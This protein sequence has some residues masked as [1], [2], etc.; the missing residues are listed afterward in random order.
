MNS[1]NSN[2]LTSSS[3][4]NIIAKRSV[5]EVTEESVGNCK[6]I[7]PNFQEDINNVVP[8]SHGYMTR[9]KLKQ[10]Q[11]ASDNHFKTNVSLGTSFDKDKSIIQ[12]IKTTKKKK[13]KPTITYKKKVELSYDNNIFGTN[14][15]LIKTSFKKEKSI[16]QPRKTI[17]IKKPSKTYKSKSKYDVTFNNCLLADKQTH[18]Q[19]Q[20]LPSLFESDSDLEIDYFQINHSKKSKVNE[21]FASSPEI[22]DIRPVFN[23][24][25]EIKTYYNKKSNIVKSQLKATYNAIGNQLIS[26]E[27]NFLEKM[28][29]CSVFQNNINSNINTTDVMTYQNTCDTIK[30][31][32]NKKLEMFTNSIKNHDS[33]LNG[34][35]NFKLVKSNK[36][37][38][39]QLDSKCCCRS[40][41]NFNKDANK[42]STSKTKHFAFDDDKK[43]FQTFLQ[44][45][46]LEA[47]MLKQLI[48][49]N[50]SIIQSEGHVRN[51]NFP[52]F[53]QSRTKLISVDKNNHIEPYISQ[54]LKDFYVDFDY[55]SECF[56]SDSS[57][58]ELKGSINLNIKIYNEAPIPNDN[59]TFMKDEHLN[60]K[61]NKTTVITPNDDHNVSSNKNKNDVIP[62]RQ[63]SIV[64]DLSDH[65]NIERDRSSNL[66]KDTI[67]DNV[68][69]SDIKTI[70]QTNNFHIFKEENDNSDGRSIS[71]MKVSKEFI[72]NPKT[73]EK[74]L[75][76]LDKN[77]NTVTKITNIKNSDD[78]IV[79]F[80]KT[81][82]NFIPKRQKSS[83][84]DLSDHN[85]IERDKSSNLIKDTIDDNVLTSNVKTFKLIKNV[86]LLKEKN[87]NLD[88]NGIS[89]VKLSKKSC[90]KNFVCSNENI[91]TETKMSNIKN[92]VDHIVEFNETKN[93]TI[94][95]QHNSS[96]FN[97]FDYN[98]IE[99]DSSSDDDC[100]KL[101]IDEKL[102]NSKISD[103]QIKNEGGVQ[104][105][106]VNAKKTNIQI[107]NEESVQ[108]RNVNNRNMNTQIKNDQDNKLINLNTDTKIQNKNAIKSVLPKKESILCNKPDNSCVLNEAETTLQD[109]NLF[110]SI[111][112]CNEFYKKQPLNK[113]ISFNENKHFSKSVQDIFSEMYVDTVF[114][115]NCQHMVELCDGQLRNVELMNIK[116]QNYKNKMFKE[117]CNQP[118]P[119]NIQPITEKEM[120]TNCKQSNKPLLNPIS[121]LQ[122]L[123]SSQ[124]QKNISNI[125]IRMKLREMLK[126]NQPMNV[127]LKSTEF[128]NLSNFCE[129]E[130][131]STICVLL[132][133]NIFNPLKITGLTT[134]GVN[135]E[136]M[137]NE[138]KNELFGSTNLSITCPKIMKLTSITLE[139]VKLLQSDRLISMILNSIRNNILNKK[140][141]LNNKTDHQLIMQTLYLVDI[142]NRLGMLKYIQTF[143][144]DSIVLLPNKYC[145]VLFM[146][147]MLWNNCLPVKLN[148]EQD[149]VI[150]MAIS[151]LIAKRKSYSKINI[152]ATV[153]HNI[154]QQELIN[155][156]SFYYNYSFTVDL[157]TN[158]IKHKHKPDFFPSVMMVLKCSYAKDMVEFTIHCLFPIIEEYLNTQ[159]DEAYAIQTMESIFHSFKLFRFSFRPT[160]TGY[161]NSRKSTENNFE[162]DKTSTYTTLYQS[163]KTLLN[164]MIEYINDSR[165]RSQYFEELLVSI[166]MLLG[167]VDYCTCC[168]I[169]MKW[170]PKFEPSP[171]L[172][173]KYDIFKSILGHT[174][175]NRLCVIDDIN[176]I[177]CLINVCTL[178]DEFYHTLEKLQ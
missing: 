17:Q 89:N 103:I 114:V 52:L 94:P 35:L 126:S 104:L 135:C 69:T 125:Q 112:K 54:I 28:S 141:N 133:E 105:M 15:S 40:L 21:K 168:A 88:G 20:K 37:A 172:T 102:I 4:Q 13:K 48:E 47:N 115:S 30:H 106:N 73:C 76:S 39:L 97:L 111:E 71:N 165:P 62:K 164:K 153:D 138:E 175:W 56:D 92:S 86:N 162:E 46:Q 178:G 22:E 152:D 96:L 176:T 142:C 70:K 154:Y 90:E 147:L 74:N 117:K 151:Y 130:I 59:L 25:A 58:D 123:N 145:C 63:N 160:V 53:N 36:S 66:I 174:L 95:K 82:N 26:E 51:L 19:R 159:Q 38:N 148:N 116:N 158:L 129:E 98:D 171:I 119:N 150:I 6:K 173:R 101:L 5:F 163:Y 10:K 156:L 149:P 80:N 23:K 27:N 64:F 60:T 3:Y 127:I 108:L 83:L 31:E 34:N 29:D 45:K 109:Y 118:I 12:P 124:K 43:K 169:L 49:S 42:I 146:S 166:I 110:M 99:S 143:I 134:F 7:K 131:S 61:T 91:N 14:I 55:L 18:A 155:L 79:K 170:E 78:H 120:N 81:K 113:G 75:D 100:Y 57:D 167:C 85:N 24:N 77:I 177:M 9:H 84:F 139:L 2:L 33:F 144:W 44:Q 132:F 72:I 161:L 157:P 136:N 122:K 41:F 137:N 1:S 107:K 87:D 16:I 8:A 140:I 32:E 128:K 68:L 67:D 50:E 93:C 121:T 11:L 65:N